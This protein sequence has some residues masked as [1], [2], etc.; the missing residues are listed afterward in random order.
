[1]EGLEGAARSKL[2]PTGRAGTPTLKAKSK[3]GSR[4]CKILASVG[5]QIFY[6]KGRYAAS[7][8]NRNSATRQCAYFELI[9]H[10]LLSLCDIFF[11]L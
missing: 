6:F 9:H 1:M 5:L 11:L 10:D 4:K 3:I 2:S 8:E 7:N